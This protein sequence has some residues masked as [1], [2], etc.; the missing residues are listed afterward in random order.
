MKHLNYQSKAPR[1]QDWA[2]HWK[3]CKIYVGK[4][5]RHLETNTMKSLF[6]VENLEKRLEQVERKRRDVRKFEF[7]MHCVMSEWS[8]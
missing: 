6:H 4:N 2:M 1:F 5:A 3:F 8:T 7:P